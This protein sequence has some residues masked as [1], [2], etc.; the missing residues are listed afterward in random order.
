M[1]ILIRRGDPADASRLA[2]F[3]AR[4]FAET[5]GADNRPDD[6]AAHL[7]SSY[8]VAQQSREL[9]DPD[10]VT[11]L[12]DS[13][14]GLGGYAQVRRHPPPACVTGPDPIELHRFYVDAAWHGQGVAQ[15]LMQAVHAV[16][17]EA[18][19]RT[20]WLSVWERNPR[21]RAFYRKCGF[22]DVGATEFHVGSDRQSDR[23]LAMP[24]GGEPSGVA[25]PRRPPPAPR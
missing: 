7:A 5:F 19:G 9:S 1:T 14:G 4:T 22:Q 6:L 17:A 21:A 12:A 2:A 23:V 25:R 11:L 10:W 16:A 15:R 18:G 3:A 8:G 24:V 20:L 13:G